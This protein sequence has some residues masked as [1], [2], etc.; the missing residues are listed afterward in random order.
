MYENHEIKSTYSWTSFIPPSV[1]RISLLSG[2][3]LAVYI[4][5]FQ[6]KSCSWKKKYTERQKKLITSSHT[7]IHSIKINHIWTQIS[8]HTS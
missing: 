1:I 3:D 6:L 7:K 8:F 5:Y 4:V 2:H